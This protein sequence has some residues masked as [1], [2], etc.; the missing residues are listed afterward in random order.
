M[1]CLLDLTENHHAEYCN[2]HNFD[3]LPLRVNE[4]EYPFGVGDWEKV[5][6]LK[7]YLSQ[8]RFVVWLDADAFIADPQTDLRDVY[9]ENKIGAVQL[10]A[11]YTWGDHFNVGALYCGQGNDVSRFMDAWL[12]GYP[13]DYRQREQGVFNAIA[14]DVV[15]ELPPEWNYTVDRHFGIENPFVRGYHSIRETDRKLSAMK[16][17]MEKIRKVLV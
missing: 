3:Y 9:R 7:K 2:F 5:Y 12:D 6:F 15:F 10:K 4:S 16:R 13:G 14:G 11:P 1:E 17:D 8:Y